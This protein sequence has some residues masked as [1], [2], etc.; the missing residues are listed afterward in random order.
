MW[1]ATDGCSAQYRCAT[2]I[3]FL[4]LL[5]FEK[6]IAID[7]AISAPGHGK[8]IADGISGATKQFLKHSQ[9]KLSRTPQNNDFFM[10]NAL[11]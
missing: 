7:R 8:G 5:S 6:D 3:F 11:S 2:A 4:A 1:D 9:M 10:E